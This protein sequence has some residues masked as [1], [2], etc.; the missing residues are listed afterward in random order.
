MP[1]TKTQCD[2]NKEAW[3]TV[4]ANVALPCPAIKCIAPPDVACVNHQCVAK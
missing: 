2:A 4:C 3:M 1:M